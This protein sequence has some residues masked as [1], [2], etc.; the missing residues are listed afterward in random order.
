MTIRALALAGLIAAATPPQPAPFQLIEATVDDVRAALTSKRITCRALVEL[1]LQRI[2]AYDKTGPALNTIQT[3]NPRARQEADRLDA[4]M[5]ASGRRALH[6]AGA[7]QDQVETSDMR[8]PTD[9]PSSRSSSPARDATIV[10]KLKSGRRHHRE[11]RWA[12]R[13]RLHRFGVRRGPQRRSYTRAAGD[14]RRHQ[15]G[16]RPTSGSSASARTPADRSRSGVGE[17]PRRRGRRCRSSAASMMPARP[18]TDIGRSQDGECRDLLDA[19][20]GYDANGGHGVCR[21]TGP[22]VIRGSVGDGLKVRG[23]G[24]PRVDGSR[25]DPASTTSRCGR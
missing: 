1:Y 23:S 4:A 10:S 8:R 20:A 9:R 11:R 19:I 5:A 24:D 12:M 15:V 13:V 14:R 17:Q 2:E 18:T 22:G 21:R 7:A 6:R 25:T 3:V 16:H